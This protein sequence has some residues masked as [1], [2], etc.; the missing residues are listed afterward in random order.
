LRGKQ[1]A[2]HYYLNAHPNDE[3]KQLQMDW[4]MNN[5]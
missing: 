3:N 4:S 1:G 2:W 5:E